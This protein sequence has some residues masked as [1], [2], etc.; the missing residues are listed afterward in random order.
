MTNKYKIILY[1]IFFL[2]SI[3]AF[4]QIEK[5]K[6]PLSEILILL[7]EKYEYSFTYANDVIK[8]IYITEP[9][10]NLSLKKTIAYLEKETGLI[11]YFLENN[12]ITIHRKNTSFFVCGYII[13]NDTKL[14]L[15]AVTIND[16]GEYTTSDSFGYFKIKVHNN[17]EH[18]TIRHLGHQPISIPAYAFKQ[19]DCLTIY[20]AT[21]IEV[22]SEIS[23]TNYI[24]RGIDKISDG[25]IAMNFSNF[26]ILP[27]LIETDVLQTVQALPGIQS[28]NETISNINI[29]GGTN[30]QNLLLWDGIKM[31]QSGHFFGLISVFNP[32]MTTDAV[33]IKNGTGVD[34]TDG[35]SGTIAMKTDTK[36]NHTFNGSIGINFINSD[37][38][39]D[40]PLGKKSSLQLSA[41]KAINEWVSTTPTYK[42]YFDRILQDTEVNTVIDQNISFD[43]HDISSRW[44]YDISDKD[45]L[46]INFLNVDNRL[47]FNET[48]TVNDLETSKESSLSQKS[49]AGGFYYKR[50]WNSQFASTL[51][52]TES[53]YELKA[54]NE[55]IENQQR[56]LQ[57]N[58]VTETSVKLNTWY[59]L[60]KE[61]SLLNGY[62][63]TETVVTNLT[64]VD[65]PLFLL[66]IKEVIR[67]HA[68]YS[69]INYLSNNKK[70]TLKA[71]LRYNYI[72]KFKKHIIEPRLT[73]HQKIHKH[74]S[75]DILGELKH[76]NTSQVI[77]FQND[78]L[79]IEK[80]RWILSDDKT[81]PV[82]K[83]KQASMGINYNNKGWLVSTE[84]FIKKV[85]GIT[86]QSQG[87]LNQY[88]PKEE[89]GS[90]TVKGVEFLINKRFQK[91][92]TWLSYTYANNEYTFKNFDEI[93]FPNN[94]DIRHTLIFGTSFTSTN[95]KIAAGFS[96]HSGK[97]TTKPLANN[98][99]T[100]NIINYEP[101][102]SS[103]L[104]E[105]LRIDA[106]VLYKF[107]IFKNI[108]AQA[109]VSIWNG[110][111][112]NNIFTNY[113]EI[114]NSLPKEISNKALLFTPNISFR[115]FF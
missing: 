52:V 56:L 93:N 8:D 99:V 86:S 59:Q 26:G 104:K 80:R 76:Q 33:I 90:Y 100:N 44:L 60:N 106:S 46:R 7:Q 61:L 19:D 92:S 15:E 64:D 36:I 91:I 2:F 6:K 113:Y 27:G 16:T 49:V 4:S 101:A 74:L 20:L 42:K 110:L 67:E 39:I 115:V 102:N 35:V 88:S 75:I 108:K 78:F 32:L 13:D 18:L 41:R 5:E 70:T 63:F 28:I 29:R 68:A 58:E 71:G 12:I 114:E 79:G 96:W 34:L 24:T 69:Q 97:P 95:F 111:N 98:S 112:R 1:F 82:L 81:I 54:I 22:L 109:G 53:Y 57:E 14:P 66:S 31:Y 30:D 25:T 55:E 84:G 48:A 107:N 23:L 94:F 105:Y 103:R 45:Q 38:F 72:E 62:Q 47:V 65:N 21:Q 40:M 89:N 17:N 3:T 50:K 85:D 43:F 9:P 73:F 51:Q 10:H 77:N 87:F 83:S 37:G 11:F